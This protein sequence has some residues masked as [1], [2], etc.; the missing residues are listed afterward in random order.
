MGVRMV[1][2]PLTSRERVARVLAGEIPD[3]V[4]MFDSYWTTTVERWRREGLPAGIS[5][6]AYFGTDDIT[7]IGGDYTMQFPERVLEETGAS[8][9]YWDADGALRRDLHVEEGWTSQWLE[10]T[11]KTQDDWTRHRGRMAFTPARI[12]DSAVEAYERARAADRFVCYSGHAC[13]HPTWMRIGMEQM[14][15]LMLDD[16]GFIHRLFADH[17][18]L[19]IDIYEAFVARGMTFDGAFMAD[20]L[21]Y[22]VAPL[23]S[24]K[25]YRELVYPHHKRLCDRFAQDGLKTILHSDGNI[26]PLIPH[27]LDAGFA[28]LHPLEAKAGL[29][30]RDLKPRY[31][32]RLVLIGNIDVRELATSGGESPA[33]VRARIE[34]EIGEKVS[35]AK[36]GGGYIYH[37]DHSVPNDVP[38]EAYTYAIQMVKQYGTYPEA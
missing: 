21:G 29:D 12:P 33:A 16:P 2:D 25:L 1:R 28:G 36:A 38:L 17:V 8:R 5:P 37:S 4:P 34:A 9:L 11:I 3:R 7:R 24:P 27:F 30:V 15:M 32:D 22:Q 14:L 6:D 20:D 23:I 13:F 35:A 19:I 31:G 26:A 10:F 18:Q